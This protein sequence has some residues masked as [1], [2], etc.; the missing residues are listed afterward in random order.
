MD[1]KIASL[2]MAH[3]GNIY[4]QYAVLQENTY[5]AHT[6]DFD[7]LVIIIGGKGEHFV[8][9]DTYPIQAGDVFVLKGENAHSFKHIENLALLSISHFSKIFRQVYHLSPMDYLQQIRLEKARHLLCKSELS[10]AEIAIACGFDNSN[11]FSRLFKK[12]HGVPPTKW[13]LHNNTGSL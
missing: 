1:T 7:E 4:V 3:P 6:H 5:P 13:E 8:N 9:G 2:S 11:Y 10:V 12:K